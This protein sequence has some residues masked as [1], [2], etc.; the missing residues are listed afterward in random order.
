MTTDPTGLNYLGELSGGGFTSFSSGVT[1][2][3]PCIGGKLSFPYA[4]FNILP[5]VMGYNITG[6]NWLQYQTPNVVGTLGMG[7]DSPFWT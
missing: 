2:A 7:I 4:C 3:T 1:I 5:A 6:D